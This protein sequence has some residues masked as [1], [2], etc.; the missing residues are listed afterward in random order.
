MNTTF[1]PERTDKE[2]IDIS[3]KVRSKVSKLLASQYDEN[4]LKT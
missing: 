4:H 3:K 1:H 2:T